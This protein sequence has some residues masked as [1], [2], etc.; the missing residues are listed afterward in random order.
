MKREYF[1]SESGLE[2]RMPDL[3]Q[4]FPAHGIVR[5]ESRERGTLVHLSQSTPTFLPF[6][7]AFR[8]DFVDALQA[9]IKKRK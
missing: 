1:V 2:I 5:L 8:S 3:T 6:G 7:S 9:V 4:T